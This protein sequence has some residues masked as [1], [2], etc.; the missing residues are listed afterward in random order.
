VFHI[1][2]NWKTPRLVRMETSG[3]RR[4]VYPI[5]KSFCRDYSRLTLPNTRIENH[6]GRIWTAVDKRFSHGGL[7]HSF[8]LIVL[9]GDFSH[10]M[11][12][13]TGCDA[14]H[15]PWRTGSTIEGTARRDASRLFMGSRIKSRSSTFLSASLLSVYFYT[16]PAETSPTRS[17]KRR[18]SRC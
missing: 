10:A 3:N 18:A 5:A 14:G 16:N 11:R 4:S 9:I 15:C 13:T 2:Q 8:D 12:L 7:P 6:H 17:R 1:T